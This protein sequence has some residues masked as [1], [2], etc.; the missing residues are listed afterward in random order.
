MELTTFQSHGNS[1]LLGLY[2]HA[3]HTFSKHTFEIQ[4]FLEEMYSKPHISQKDTTLIASMLKESVSLGMNYR[5]Y[6]ERIHSYIDSIIKD[7][8]KLKNMVLGSY[9]NSQKSWFFVRL[10]ISKIKNSFL[11]LNNAL[12]QNNRTKLCP[13]E[14]LSANQFFVIIHQF[15]VEVRKLTELSHRI[16]YNSYILAEHEKTFAKILRKHFNNHE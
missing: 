15:E 4:C 12:F 5:F 16:E 3:E 7:L 1:S 6:K 14:T 9:R 13:K 2:L 11:Y 10:L 8:K